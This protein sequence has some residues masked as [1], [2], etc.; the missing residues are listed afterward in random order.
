MDD[1]MF[2]TSTIQFKIMND[3]D[4]EREEEEDYEEV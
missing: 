1:Y 3:D 4:E 2:E